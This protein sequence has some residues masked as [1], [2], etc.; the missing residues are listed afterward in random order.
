MRDY[1]NKLAKYIM[2]DIEA[3]RN[4]EQKPDERLGIEV[5]ALN[6][7]C[8]AD[9]RLSADKKRRDKGKNEKS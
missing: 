8:N 2:E 1:I 4:R 9:S 5:M 7:L 3:V 6:A